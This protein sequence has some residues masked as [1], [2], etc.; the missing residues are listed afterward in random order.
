MAQQ[1][2][3]PAGS[4]KAL[5][6]ELNDLRNLLQ[7]AAESCRGSISGSD[8]VRRS[9]SHMDN[10]LAALKKA[11]NAA[12]DLQ[13]SL[14]TTAPAAPGRTVVLPLHSNGRPNPGARFVGK[15]VKK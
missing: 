3:T 1:T 15:Q 4:L 11:E 13:R 10:A 9:V 8:A 7:R 6:V 5:A 14:G 12:E 2:K